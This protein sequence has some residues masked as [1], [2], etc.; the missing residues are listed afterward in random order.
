M[1]LAQEEPMKTERPK[2]PVKTQPKKSVRN[3]FAQQSE[4][5][6]TLPQTKCECDPFE[7]ILDA[8]AQNPERWDGLE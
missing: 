5:A 1:S 2:E 6:K 7:A 8:Y 3:E 4:P